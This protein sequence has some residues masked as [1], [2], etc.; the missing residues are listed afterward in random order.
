MQLLTTLHRWTGGIVGLILAII[1]LSGTVLVWEDA[2]ISLPGAGEGYHSTTAD[3]ALALNVAAAEEGRELTRMTF[4]DDGMGL[5]LAAY[6]D[7]GGAYVDQSGRI[8]DSW[9][10]LWGRP[11][12]WLFDLHHY[13]FLGHSGE[14]VAGAMGVLLFAFVITGVILWW[15]TRKTF[16]FRLWPKRM[17]R[18]AIIRQHRDIGMV[19]APMLLISAVT[20][21]LMIFSPLSDALLSPL[22]RSGG[23]VAQ[24]E[25]TVGTAVGHPDYGALMT[26]GQAAF[27]DARPRRFQTP[28]QPGKPAVLRLRQASEWTPNGRSYAYLDPATGALVGTDDPALGDARQSLQEKFYPVHA[29]KVGG[30]VWKLLLTFG[31]L[32]LILLGTLASWSFWFRRNDGTVMARK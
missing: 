25:Y 3:L 9:G 26:N 1:G 20:G 6:A 4:A 31:G 24:P 12:L 23:D 17:S 14:Y 8:V 28:K 19:A 13:L 11:E 22:A 15:R 2:W 30:V 27:P 32:A 5:H 29:G 18:S 7:G 16:A 10:S 21:A